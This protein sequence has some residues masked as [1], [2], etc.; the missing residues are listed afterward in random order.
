MQID[1]VPIAR[2]RAPMPAMPPEE[3]APRLRVRQIA[4]ITPASLPL[5]WPNGSACFRRRIAK[6]NEADGTGWDVRDED[7]AGF[8][9]RVVNDGST[10]R[11]WRWNG[12]GYA[13][14]GSFPDFEAVTRALLR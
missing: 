2:I 6:L 14:L 9:G 1:Q 8:I 7:R 11:A 3:P 13:F 10:Q 12:T 5:P 4:P